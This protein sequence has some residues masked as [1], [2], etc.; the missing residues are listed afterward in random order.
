MRIGF[1]TTINQN[2]GDDFI[3]EGIRNILESMKISYTPLYVNKHNK[4]SL[5]ESYEDE[6]EVVSDK[7][8]YSDF[9]IQSGTPVYWSHENGKHSSLTSEWYGW[10]WQDRILSP[11]GKHPRFIN[12]GAGSCQPWGE[13]GDKFL[14][15]KG[16]CEYTKAAAARSE[17]TTVRDPVASYILTSLGIKHETLACPAFL[18]GLRHRRVARDRVIGIN[19]MAVGGHWDLRDIFDKSSWQNKCKRLCNLLRDQGKLVFICHDELEQKFAEKFAKSDE[20]VFLST[21]WRKYFDMFTGCS[22]LV[23]NRVHGAVCAAGLGVPSIILG[24]D[25]R[26]RIGEYV[27]IPFLDSQELNPEQ[28]AD[29]VRERL[30]NRATFSEKLLANQQTTLKSY[31]KLLAPFFGVPVE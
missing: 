13:N 12:L 6:S 16:C 1:M 3:R 10:L 19:L 29:M 22:V 14:E 31:Q 23:A 30:N 28:I 26:A 2:V 8:R 15:N 18:A 25:T 5:W 24:N 4:K 21:E 11:K 27:G 17:L 9:F 7:Y 20:R